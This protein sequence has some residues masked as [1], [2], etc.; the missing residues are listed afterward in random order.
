VSD[1][2]NA[3]GRW[4]SWTPA[5]VAVLLTAV[6]RF[7][8]YEPVAWPEAAY[9]FL[10]PLLLLP[11]QGL[12]SRRALLLGWA[13]GF[14]F[15][16]SS[17]IWLRHVTLVGTL[18]LAAVLGLFLAVWYLA[19]VRS[20]R[21]GLS[22][23]TAALLLASL[24]VVLEW[25]RGWILWG[26]PWNP[27]SVSQASRPAVLALA[28]VTGGWGISFLLVWTNVALA[29]TLRR[30]AGARPPR[31]YLAL[32]RAGPYQVLLP[33][34]ILLGSAVWT[35]AAFPGTRTA[36]GGEDGSVRVGFVQPYS[37]M[38]R[39]GGSPNANL[40]DLW[41]TTRAVAAAGPDLLLWPESATPY[42]VVGE[43]RMR[44]AIEQ[45]VEEV[46]R[47]LLMG[48][49]AFPPGEDYYE[50]AVFLVEPGR[51]LHPR[52]YAKRELVPFG[53]FLPFRAWIPFLEKAVGIGEDARPGEG[54]VLLPFPVPGQGEIGPLVCYEDVFPGLARSNVR[55]GADWLFVA[56]NN[57]WYGEEAGA[58]QHAAHAVLRAVETRRPVL[59]S[60][61]AGWSGW[62]D[63]WG[64]ARAVTDAEG[65]IYFRGGEVLPVRRA[66]R[67]AGTLTPYVRYGDWWVGVCG[68]L[69]AAGFLRLRLA[70][71]KTGET[72]DPPA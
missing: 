22:G 72:G 41:A 47:P 29:E 7:A 8:L 5:L 63:E 53:E 46:D 1:R 12:S 17:L 61:I 30:W 21:R 71:R 44:R 10:L 48:N 60:G 33:V 49:L 67:F 6:L 55:A 32:H 4:R 66:P 11:V 59:R 14:L 40:A 2:K 56:T 16:A 13:S 58:P 23:L 35:V 50:N 39:E 43:E 65:S 45:L 34:G 68:L 15:W 57:V 51:G 38:L 69:L 9:F 62:I 37:T 24:W 3:G 28:S 42:P 26:F 64:V 52:W 31:R 54:P 19:H 27:L 25:V 36:S 70:G 18:L 20:Q